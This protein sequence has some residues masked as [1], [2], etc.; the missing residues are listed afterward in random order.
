[1]HCYINWA[2]C[3]LPTFILPDWQTP[4]EKFTVKTLHIDFTI[5]LQARSRNCCVDSD[6]LRIERNVLMF[7]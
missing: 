3:N 6:V 5:I 7:L 1:M 2:L 4:F